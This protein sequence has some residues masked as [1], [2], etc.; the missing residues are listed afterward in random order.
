M[1]IFKVSSQGCHIFAGRGILGPR[2][3]GSLGVPNG[4]WV[5]GALNNS[6]GYSWNT[7]GR[8]PRDVSTFSLGASAFGKLEGQG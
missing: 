5:S 6:R 3:L 1:L 8:V 7:R 4:L 2:S